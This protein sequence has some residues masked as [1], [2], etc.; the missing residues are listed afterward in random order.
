[1]P[2]LR[3]YQTLEQALRANNLRTDVVMVVEKHIMSKC[4]SGGFCIFHYHD[5]FADEFKF[6]DSVKEPS[7]IMMEFL[8]GK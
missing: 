1:M 5:G 2:T 7:C 3:Y 6:Y 4:K 8:K